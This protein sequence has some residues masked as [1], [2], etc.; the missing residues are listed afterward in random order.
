[1]DTQISEQ[2]KVFNQLGKQM[3]EVYHSYAVHHGM[4]DTALWILWIIWDCKTGYTQRELS[5]EWHCSPQT[6][7]SAL[8]ILEKQGLVELK[9]APGSKKNKQIHLTEIG[10][11]FA[12]QVVE[13]LVQAEHRAFAG[14]DEQERIALVKLLRKHATLLAEEIRKIK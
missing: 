2:L 3:D 11:K 14:F 1:M 4:S 6:I 13:P 8:K 7:N 12:Q 5:N 10:Q 9:L